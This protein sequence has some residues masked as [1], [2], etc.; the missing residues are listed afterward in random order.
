MRFSLSTVV[1]LGA[2][3]T[4]G[5]YA[6]CISDC[7][8]SVKP[9]VGCPDATLAGCVCVSSEFTKGVAECARAPNCA[10]ADDAITGFLSGGFCAGQPLGALPPAAAT[11]PTSAAATDAA[12]DA[13]T[14]AAP[15]ATTD[16]ASAS[17]V[18]QVTS[19]APEASTTDSAETADPTATEASASASASASATD[20]DSSSATSG[21]AGADATSG[22]SDD[23]DSDKDEDDNEESSGGGMSGSAKAGVGVG[24]TL[25]ILALLGVV[26]FFFWKKRQGQRDNLPRGNMAGMSPAMSGGDRGYPSPD[27]GSVGEKNG[28]DLEI[29]SHRYE[30]MLPREEPRHMV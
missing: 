21:A 16:A 9:T 7:V 10:A 11:T 3:Q 26:G 22:S 20:A 25:G 30:D 4:L 23:D 18:P 1:A 28:Y 15:D 8:D 2:L 24:V 27:Q 29:M 19:E 12:T 5:V 17:D 14:S 6:D 13:A